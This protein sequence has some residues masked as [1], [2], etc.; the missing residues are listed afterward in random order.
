M[1]PSLKLA[2]ILTCAVACSV[3]HANPVAEPPFVMTAENVLVGVTP[4][5]I[6]VAGTYRYRM[7]P[8]YARYGAPERI[9][10]PG[11]VRLPIPVP[12]SEKIDAGLMHQVHPELTFQGEVF[13][14]IDEYGHFTSLPDVEGVQFMAVYFDIGPISVPE[15]EVTIRYTQPLIERDG[16]R[17][18]YYLPL[19]EGF[20]RFDEKLGLRESSYAV[21]F[22]T[23]GDSTLRLCGQPT[24]VLQE[25]PQ[26]ISVEAHNREVI[27]VELI[28]DA[29]G[30]PVE[31]TQTEAARLR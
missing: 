29:I 8:V 16:K 30:E 26:L 2:A 27:A 23:Y 21:S 3:A 15:I 22:E 7:S 17:L 14:P 19:L 11:R 25:T 18:A 13:D 20:K 10:I 31:E 28:P 12:A 4:Q 24:K 5:G 1:N 9:P 6:A